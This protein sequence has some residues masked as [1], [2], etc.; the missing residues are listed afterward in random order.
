MFAEVFKG[1]RIFMTGHTG[2]KGSWLTIWLVRLGAE[3]CGYSLEP[4]SDPNMFSLMGLGADCADIQ[5][6][7]RDLEKLT[8]EMKLFS[9]DLVI[10]MAAQPLVRRS[11]AEPV[12]TFAVNVMG[13]VNVLE[14]ARRTDSIQAVINV[15]S[16]KCY[17]NTEAGGSF[18][19]TDPMGGS[20]PYS[21]SKGCA[22]LVINSWRR[23]FFREGGPLLASVRAGNVIGGGD[24]AEDRLLPD[25]VRAFS[26]NKKV[27]IRSPRAIR[28]WQFVLEP[29]CGYLMLAGQ[30]LQGRSE[31]A[32]AW[33]FGP[34]DSDT[35]T[36][37]QVVK[38]FAGQWGEGTA[39]Q[40][41]ENDHPHEAA[42]L[43]LDCSKATGKLGWTP[44]TDVGTAIAWA[45]EWYQAWSS[46]LAVL[47]SL[48]EEQIRR[49]EEL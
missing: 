2:F 3:V 20:D 12:E 36:V 28:P 38:A 18:R 39:S 48:T 33:N 41:D 25:M 15:T 42:V 14:A 6:D 11:Y 44:K 45:V 26:R 23:S 19:E 4:P 34:T 47:R 21:A 24:F 46:G 49:F 43:R 7:I 32:E 40:L 29:L 31:F 1:K 16:D 13:T 27:H 10:H 5:G 37:G 30:L 22:E 17:E 35:M 9:P 8:Q